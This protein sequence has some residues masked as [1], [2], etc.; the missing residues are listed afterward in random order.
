MKKAP[1]LTFP[2]PPSGNAPFLE[3]L[4]LDEPE[5]KASTL[6]QRLRQ[7]IK[8]GVLENSGNCYAIGVLFSDHADHSDHTDHADH[9]DHTRTPVQSVIG[10]ADSDRTMPKPITPDMP[11]ER[12]PKTIIMIVLP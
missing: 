11:S 10:S 2:T 1:I 7:M 8:A 9:T 4:Q 12:L 6:R 5:L 3:E